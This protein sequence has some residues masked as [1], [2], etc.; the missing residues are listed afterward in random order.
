MLG[1]IAGRSFDYAQDDETREAE[2]A[3][4]VHRASADGSFGYAQD[5]ET[6]TAVESAGVHRAVAVWRTLFLM[7][8][9]LYRHPERSRRIYS[10]V[11][12]KGRTD[13]KGLRAFSVARA[14]AEA[15]GVLR[16]VAVWRTLF[17]LR[18]PLAR[19]PERSRRIQQH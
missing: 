11:A 4:G 13:T 15:A 6:G 18:F 17:L 19:H 3:A 7:R 9:P 12:E 10:A 14:A 1:A 5:D 16:A 2:E 8:F